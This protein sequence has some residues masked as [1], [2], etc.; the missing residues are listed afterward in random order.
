MQND[1]NTKGNTQWFYFRISNVPAN[2]DIKI[3][4]VNMMKPDSLFN[5]G[6]LPCVH[7][8]QAELKSG[9]GWVRKA[10]KVS[11][12]KNTKRVENSKRYYYTLS[13]TISSTYQNDVLKIAQCFP[14]T[15]TNLKDYINNLM[16]VHGK[17]GY[18]FQ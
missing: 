18:L 7:S 4:I 3:N 17:K 15:L 13:F 12:Y 16:K 8:A 6:M 5:Y 14:Y 11:Y 9:T 1:I 2:Q 10:T